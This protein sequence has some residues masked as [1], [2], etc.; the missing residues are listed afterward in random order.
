MLKYGIIKV[1]MRNHKRGLPVEYVK[2]TS[3]AKF[4][5]VFFY[6]LVAFTQNYAN[7]YN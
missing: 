4:T 2:N 1:E 6:W 3:T 5:D 7:S